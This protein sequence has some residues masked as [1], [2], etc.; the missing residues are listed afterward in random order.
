MPAG[1][2]RRMSNKFLSA[3]FYLWFK[4]ITLHCILTIILIRCEPSA[5]FA[6]RFYPHG[7]VNYFIPGSD[8]GVFYLSIQH[9]VLIISQK[10]N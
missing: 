2:L 10:I 1:L 5:G 7:F 8:N 4:I 3:G 9:L 6:V